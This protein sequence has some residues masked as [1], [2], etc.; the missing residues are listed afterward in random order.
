VAGADA[1]LELLI[2][3]KNN[4]FVLTVTALDEIAEKH[5]AVRDQQLGRLFN[6]LASSLPSWRFYEEKRSVREAKL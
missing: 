3:A 4:P 5:P 2:E 1:L 6:K